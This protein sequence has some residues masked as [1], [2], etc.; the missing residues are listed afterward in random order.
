MCWSLWWDKSFGFGFDGSEFNPIEDSSGSDI[1]TALS[2]SLICASESG[3]WYTDAKLETKV[4][5]VSVTME[6]LT[7]GRLQDSQPMLNLETAVHNVVSANPRV[8]A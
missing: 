2:F 5:V 8:E 7:E 6:E 4:G 1:L 3:I